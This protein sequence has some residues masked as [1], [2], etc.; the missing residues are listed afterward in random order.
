MIKF[1]VFDVDGT[2]VDSVDMHAKAWQEVFKKHGKAIP[3]AE[4]RGQIGKGGDRFDS[5][6]SFDSP[7]R[8]KDAAV[9]LIDRAEGLSLAKVTTAPPAGRRMKNGS[10][11]LTYVIAQHWR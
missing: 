1:V 2:L 11:A 10:C 3:F 7:P 4:I 5:I 8:T 6:G 9:L